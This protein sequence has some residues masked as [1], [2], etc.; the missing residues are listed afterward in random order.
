[1]LFAALSNI[2]T[3]EGSYCLFGLDVPRL[4]M[5][6]LHASKASRIPD[7]RSTAPVLG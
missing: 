4:M 5:S 7:Y 1:M 2:E 6:P 3:F